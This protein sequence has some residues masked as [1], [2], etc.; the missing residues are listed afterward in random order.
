MAW[1]RQ[2]KNL[3]TKRTKCYRNKNQFIHSF[4]FTSNHQTTFLA[5][6]NALFPALAPAKCNFNPRRAAL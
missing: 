1:L 4:F 5:S 2:R 6:E 3:L